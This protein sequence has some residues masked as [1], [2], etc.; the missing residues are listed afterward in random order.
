MR[1][2]DSFSITLPSDRE[3]LIART[4]AA[5][6]QTVFD[7]FTKPELVRRWLL[8]PEGWTMPVCDIDLQVGGRYRYVWHKDG[9]PDMG[10]GGTFLEI[11]PATRLVN[12]EQFD[13][14]W[15]PG[16]AV[17][18]TLF[19]KKG[20][21]TEVTISVQYAST[22]ARDIASRS[23]MERG[24]IAGF[25]RLETQLLEEEAPQVTERPAGRVAAIHLTIPRN[26]ISAVMGPAL[27]ELYGVLASQGV[28][29]SGP[30]F[31]HHLEMKPDIFD[32]EVCVPVTSPVRDEG[33]VV[34]REHSARRV[35]RT[36]YRGSYEGLSGAWGGLMKWITEQGH[37]PAADLFECYAAGPET[38]ADASAWRT[39]LS[40]PLQR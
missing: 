32:F 17:N 8:G 16:E 39:E 28:Q 19:S 24:M 27:Q 14:A 36:V 23:G 6:P 35:A 31:T 3:I 40:R 22:E 15:Y 38:G 25:D 34:A 29:P 33:R 26:E 1:Y 37:T 9:V 12:T 11:V 21:G 30:W 2:P 20:A 4:F 13:D 7:A 5:S 10:M 18:T